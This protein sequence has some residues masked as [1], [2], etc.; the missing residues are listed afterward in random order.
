MELPDFEQFLAFASENQS[1]LFGDLL[2]LNITEIHWP[3]D[4]QEF[5]NLI[6]KIQ[7]DSIRQSNAMSIRFLRAYHAWMQSLD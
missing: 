7:Q 4:K 1:Q 3:L 2:K 6:E 5:A